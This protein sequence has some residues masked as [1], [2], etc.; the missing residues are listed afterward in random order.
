MAEATGSTYRSFATLADAKADPDGAVILEGDDGGQIYIVAP[1]DVVDCSEA[2]L[3]LLLRDLDAICWPGNYD[4]MAR[5]VFERRPIGT[6]V[7]GGMGGGA[8]T[9]DVWVHPALVHLGIA[10]EIRQVLAGALDRLSSE[11]RA[12]HREPNRPQLP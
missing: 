4:D 10:P 3:D 6:D 12:T 9:H 2:V 7:S 8:V 11:A 5:V 1:A